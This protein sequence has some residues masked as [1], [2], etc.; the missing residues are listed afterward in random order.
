MKKLICFIGILVLA[1]FQSRAQEVFYPKAD[2]D[3]VVVC[4]NAR[5][6]ILTPQLVRM[7]WAEDGVFED[8][9]TLGIVNRKLPVPEYKTRRSGKGVTITTSALT[10]NYTGP[11]KFDQNN[12]K[13]S[14][15][16]TGP[17]DKKGRAT[18][19]KKIWQPGADDSGNLLGTCRTLDRFD[20]TT[21]FP[22]GG[23]T[24]D[25]Y[26]KGV[27][28]RD[29][30]AIVD[31]STRHVLVP[32]DSDWKY[33][34]D[35]RPEGDRI[36]WYIFAYGHEY[37]KAL[38]DFTKVAGRIPLPPKY[39]L[40]YWWCR[41]WLYSDAELVDLADHFD[42]YSIPA[43]VFIIDM[44]W[45]ETWGLSKKIVKDPSGE[46]AGWTGYTWKKEL[47]P[48]PE[49]LLE[50]LHRRNLKTSLNLH[51]ASGIQTYE[52]PYGRFVKDYLSRTNDYDGPKDYKD[53]EGNPVYVPFR[54]DQ[55]EWA[56]AYFN[57]VIHPMEKQGVDFWWLDWQQFRNSRYTKN[58]SNTFWLNY[59]FWN[60][61]ARRSADSGKDAPRPMIYHR[62][63][64]I[65][66]H[67]YQVGFSGDTFATWK[68]LGYLPYFTATASNVGYAWWGH[69]IGGHMQ[70]KG[71][72]ET[73][74]E[75][76][77]RWLQEGVFTPIFK[78]HSTKDFSME[79]RFWVFPDH[80][81]A[82]REAIR[83]RYD[84]SPYI[85]TAARE[86]YDNGTGL[87][88]PL[89][90]AWP[91]NENSYTR[92]EEFMFGDDILATVVCQPVDK[93]TGLA[94]RSMWFPEGSDWFEMSTG[95]LYKGGT[96]AELEFTIEENP[97]FV[98]AGAIIPLAGKKIRSLQEN[99]NEI[100]LLVAP[101]ASEGKATLYEDDGKT[102]AYASD[103]ATTA[104]RQQS[105]ADGIRISIDSRKGSY[106]GMNPTRRISIELPGVSAP[107]EVYVNGEAV[108]YDRFAGMQPEDSAVWGYTGEG[109]TATVYLPELPA[110]T[111][112]T[113]E[114]KCSPVF[115]NGEKGK[116]RRLR[117]L[118]PE[119]KSEFAINIDKNMQL[120]PLLLR[121]LGT[122]SFIQEDP[123]NAA[124][125]LNAL[126]TDE[127]KAE[128]ENLALPQEF[129][130]KILAQIHD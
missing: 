125:Y 3:A 25:P 85:Y 114:C 21:V 49:N 108:P 19:I 15:K 38:G 27:V 41:Y 80:F 105:T 20:A 126:N 120:T 8:R 82:M 75:L 47:F 88:R 50:E 5:F 37:T 72:H 116:M 34:V 100:R 129:K 84:L 16:M 11:G 4:G 110:S 128:L 56:D 101:G 64:G 29:G 96:E 91:E 123:T 7:E 43:D 92:T 77:T 95:H 70:P 39:A 58:L 6:T 81:D 45:H 98:R 12:L 30:W 79:K 57:S 59:T 102:Q 69:D 97:W 17:V 55:Q 14:F 60:D 13:V 22:H 32:T 51:P 111:G 65:G 53:A 118:M 109:L 130:A 46:R 127:L 40:G 124:E 112:I 78:T 86:S 93:T 35:S 26:D 73:D 89:Y 24:Y 28:S 44:D 1:Q 90:Y 121:F 48:S 52:E 99:S 63:G 83:L 33:W 94:G 61:I 36:D 71:V 107:T 62:W 31:E 87:C 66:S 76:Y 74:P 106:K 2:E 18:T 42:S 9:A 113:V 54:I 104:I 119:V 103:Y 117:T 115:V 122:P 68:V 10:L 67:R 23:I